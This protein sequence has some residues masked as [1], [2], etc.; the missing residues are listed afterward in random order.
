V[1]TPKPGTVVVNPASPFAQHLLLLVPLT[2]GTGQ[3]GVVRGA[4][5]VTAG[6]PTTT[7]WSGTAGSWSTNAGGSCLHGTTATGGLLLSGANS[8]MPTAAIT[9]ALVFGRTGGASVAPPTVQHGS[10]TARCDL[11]LPFS[12][13]TVYWDM[14]GTASPNR[15]TKSGLGL[16][17]TALFTFVATA[18]P[19]GSA[20]YLN[21]TKVQSQGTAVS[22]TAS[23]ADTVW[24]L[25]AGAGGTA[26]G[27]FLQI[28]ADQWED[29]TVAAWS[30]DP[31]G[32]L[33]PSRPKSGFGAQKPS[34][35]R[36]H[37]RK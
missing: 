33:V 19:A 3:P 32:W 1:S 30:A 22:G 7:T 24:W 31:Y 10:G 27:N 37:G 18:G 9:V 2:E 36:Q 12:D 16:E 17:S 5:G 15:L 29:A 35:R 13:L 14:G 28:N 23:T 34:R 21:G 6:C 20:L 8:W 25:Q 26:D 11:Y 4:E